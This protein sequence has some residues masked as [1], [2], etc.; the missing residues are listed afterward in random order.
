MPIKFISQDWMPCNVM[1]LSDFI[2][3]I[4]IISYDYVSHLFMLKIIKTFP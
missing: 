1:I 4:I 3:I 2:K